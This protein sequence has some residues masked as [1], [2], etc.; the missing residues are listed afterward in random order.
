MSAIVD[1][2][3]LLF[4]KRGS[5]AYLGERVSIA[6]HMLQTAQRAE[7]DDAPPA[8]VA[9]ALLHDLG[10][11]VQPMADDS[12][13][14]GIDTVHED[15]G[16][17]WLSRTFGNEITEPIRLHVAAKRYLCATSP[18][19]LDV[20]SPASV[21]SLSLQGG[22]FSPAEAA[23]F[24][25]LPHSADAVRVRRW[26]DAGKVA[27]LATPPFDHYRSLLEVCR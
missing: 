9:A 2:I 26:D 20:L 11:L 17:D 13:D 7:A 5:R 16:A 10:H 8:L 24:G 22:P 25:A 19:Y 1:E 18:S 6:Q 12:A 15:A 14:H 27:G 4:E 21:L 23:A 3:A